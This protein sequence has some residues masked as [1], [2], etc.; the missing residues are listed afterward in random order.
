MS[1][2]ILKLLEKIGDIAE[3]IEL[4]QYAQEL[5]AEVKRLGGLTDKLVRIINDLKNR[6]A[7]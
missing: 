7:R 5:E 6:R 3:A 2:T 1:D 4:A